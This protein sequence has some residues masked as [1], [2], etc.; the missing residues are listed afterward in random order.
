MMALILFEKETDTKA[1]VT[2]IHYRPELLDEELKETGVFVEDFSIPNPEEQVG[3][4]SIL[5]INPETK[6]LW[7][8]YV[9]RLLTPEEELQQLKDRLA[10][11]QQALDD[12][13]LGGMQ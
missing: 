8:E 10:L 13:L 3:K 5:Y 7:Y 9:D 11:M 12:L 6:E 1:K 4:A 2:L